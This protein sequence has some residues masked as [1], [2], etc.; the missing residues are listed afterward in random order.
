MFERPDGTRIY[1]QPDEETDVCINAIDRPELR[2][3]YKKHSYDY[4]PWLKASRPTK[5][6]CLGGDA[7][8]AYYNSAA[9]RTLLHIPDNITQTW[10]GCLDD[11]QRETWSYTMLIKAS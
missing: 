10:T 9:V 1:P 4:T 5:K 2:A 11:V 6:V 3:P 8:G 7:L